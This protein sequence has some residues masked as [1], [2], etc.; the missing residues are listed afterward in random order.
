MK[1]ASI[2]EERAIDAIKG[3][4]KAFK[5]KFLKL[6]IVDLLGRPRGLIIPSEELDISI[7]KGVS[8]DGSS[9][10]FVGIEESDLLLMP[11]PKSFFLSHHGEVTLGNLFCFVLNPDHRP[12]A[13]DPRWTLKRSMD[14]L[15]EEGVVPKIGAE[16]EFFL[17]KGRSQHD[18]GGY[19]DLVGDEALNLKLRFSES[20][21]LAGIRPEAIHHEVAPGQHEI[22]LK[23]SEAIKIADSITIYKEFLRKI[24]SEFGLIATFMP[25]PFEEVNGSGMHLHISLWDLRGENLFWD[26]NSG[27]I[28]EITRRFIAG[29]LEHARALS[30]FVAPTVN[31]YKRLVPGYEAPVYICW[32][33]KNRSALVRVPASREDGCR[34]EFRAPDPSCNPYIAFS[35]VLGAGMDGVKRELDPGDPI[36]WNAYNTPERFE[37][38]PANLKEAVDE[39]RNDEFLR[40]WVGKEIYDAYLDM[41][42]DE[43]AEFSRS[44]TDWEI[45]RYLRIV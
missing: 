27:S 36:N 12:F 19:F 8:F 18:E 22:D 15:E 10:E 6:M 20:L 16:V 42:E 11:D 3:Q 25:K 41:L 4:I 29:L 43:W 30:A 28:S 44:V 23:F 5:I 24:A 9:L 13:K 37:S 34:I 39:A 14:K 45:K 2:S 7:G 1:Q 17:L 40:E 21:A 32:G 31:S 26:P 35:A 33:F 38:L